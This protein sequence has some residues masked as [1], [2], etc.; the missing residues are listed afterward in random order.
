MDWLKDALMA[1][2]SVFKIILN[3]VPISDFPGAFDFA[4]NDRWEGYAAQRTEILSFIDDNAIAGV[5]WLAGDFHLA[6]ISN[7]ATSGPG[8]SQ[9]EVLAGPGAQEPNAL[10]PSLTGSQFAFKTGTNNYTTLRFDPATGEVRVA[11]VDGAGTE[12]H[13]TSFVI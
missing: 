5:L 10:L 11:Y 12:F 4:Q 13:S 6:F 8:S 3:S 9:R 2:T 1:S 7:V